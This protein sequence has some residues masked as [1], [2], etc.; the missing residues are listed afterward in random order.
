MIM[1]LTV[2]SGCAWWLSRSI[3]LVDSAIGHSS[4]GSNQKSGEVYQKKSGRLL[5]YL[6]RRIRLNIEKIW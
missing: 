3:G 4:D 6:A 2:G 5:S 1:L